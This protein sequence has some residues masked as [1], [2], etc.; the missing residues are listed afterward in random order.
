MG[1]ITKQT[2]GPTLFYAGA[3]LACVFG[4]LFTFGFLAAGTY[5][6]QLGLVYV[7]VFF[8][9]GI[10]AVGWFHIGVRLREVCCPICYTFLRGVVF[11]PWARNVS[12]IFSYLVLYG[13]ASGVLRGLLFIVFFGRFKA[14]RNDRLCTLFFSPLFGVYVIATRGRFKGFFTSPS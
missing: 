14:L 5:G 10:G 7:V 6:L 1:G 13:R 11:S 12:C 2:Y 4:A 9:G 8:P 3:S